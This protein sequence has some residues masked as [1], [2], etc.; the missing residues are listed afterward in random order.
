MY[1]DGLEMM[2]ARG[3]VSRMQLQNSFIALG[4]V[5]LTLVET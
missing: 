4:R 3:W 1:M 5:M 2:T